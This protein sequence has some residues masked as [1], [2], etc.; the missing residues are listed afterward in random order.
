IAVEHLPLVRELPPGD[1]PAQYGIAATPVDGTRSH[2]AAMADSRAAQ[3]RLA[4]FRALPQE[5]AA[6]GR[7]VV[8][9]RIGRCRQHCVGVYDQSDTRA[10]RQRAGQ[11]HPLVAVSL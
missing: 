9:P 2:D 4:S 10:Q 6:S 3:E 1:A 5:T 7:Q 11:E 8:E